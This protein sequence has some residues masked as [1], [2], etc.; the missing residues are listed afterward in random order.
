MSFKCGIIGL[1][2][3]GKSLLFNLMTHSKVP[4][5]NFPFCTIKPNI[6]Y[7]SVFDT[8][9]NEI[10]KIIPAKKKTFCCIEVRDIAG[11]VKGASQGEGLGNSFLEHIKNI[12]TIIHVVRCFE[13]EKITHIYDRIDP[14]KDIEI[15]NLELLLSDLSNCQKF[16]KNFKQ[17]NLEKNFFEKKKFLLLKRCF[18]FLTK[19]I[20]LFLSD[21]DQIELKILEIYNFLTF[22]PIV[23]VLNI[24]KNIKKNILLHKVLKFI[25]KTN[26]KFISIPLFLKN[27]QQE[28]VVNI[29]NSFNAIKKIQFKERETCLKKIIQIG[30]ELLSLKTFFTVGILEIKA[31]SI[32]I[33]ATSEDAAHMIHSDLKKGFIRAQIISYIDFIKYK[34]EKGARRFGKVRSEGRKYILKDGDIVHILFNV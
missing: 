29:S 5:E 18:S 27:E 13:N 28:N 24:S 31:W 20:F 7:S 34:G 30:Y 26:S 16:L 2:N 3:V 8:R 19:G 33:N 10:F 12:N 14:I 1:P 4:S 23:Y 9:I 17:Q 15:I 22:K 25:K 6:G 32:H 21:F 11:L